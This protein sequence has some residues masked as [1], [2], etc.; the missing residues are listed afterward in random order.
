MKK[1]WLAVFGA[2]LALVQL[3]MLAGC[4]KKDTTSDPSSNV[5]STVSDDTTTSNTPG[6]TSEPTDTS[7]SGTETDPSSSSNT[8]KT[9]TTTTTT[10]TT[11]KPSP[12][13]IKTWK[14]VLSE[15][16]KNLRGKTIE[17]Y[18]YNAM[19]QI[20][21]SAKAVSGFEKATGM[22]VKWTAVGYSDYD[23]QINARMAA[24]NPP[25]VIYLNGTVMSRMQ[26]FQPLSN[27]NFDFSDGAWDQQT[28]K[29]Y[30]IKGKCYA[31][32][33]NPSYSLMHQPEAMFYN[34]DLISK[35]DLEDP[36][37][38]WQQGKWTFNKMLEL[39]KI[40]KEETGNY[41]WSFAGPWEYA[42]IKGVSCG[43]FTY[44]GK[45]VTNSF[46]TEN[47]TVLFQQMSD[48]KKAGLL[49][50]TMLDEGA[51]VTGN[52]L[53]YTFNY[54]TARSNNKHCMDMKTKGS[55]GIVPLPAI[56][57]QEK[58]YQVMGEYEGYAI[59]KAAKNAEAVPYFLR[60]YLDKANYDQKTFFCSSEAMEVYDWCMKQNR[61]MSTAILTGQSQSGS[62]VEAL[63]YKLYSATSSAITT[64]IKEAE[65]TL[66]KDVKTL[67][68]LL[69][70]F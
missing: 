8:S 1:R 16:P 24:D 55:F 4:G 3:L 6:G 10:T 29:D 32:A 62:A 37:K 49:S 22:K 53:F 14:Q 33:L 44:D 34:K 66:D 11:K 39:V 25:D 12:G 69:S 13:G 51:F 17:F 18:T 27:I 67:N 26:H 38:L 19:N 68:E 52:M 35:Y 41:G 70:K 31:T 54:G 59:P 63:G 64:V 57:G 43:P 58:Y 45:T 7:A 42:A 61:V 9:S 23:L 48:W 56:D 30:T 60:Y 36:Y 15:M 65:D 5:N 28:M 50:T 47:M 20:S 46:K 21:G 2:T 40:F